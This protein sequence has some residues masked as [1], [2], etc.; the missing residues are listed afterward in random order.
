MERKE[1]VY[2]QRPEPTALGRWLFMAKE[3]GRR[4]K[5]WTG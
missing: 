1:W 3:R 2:R 4:Q 5:R